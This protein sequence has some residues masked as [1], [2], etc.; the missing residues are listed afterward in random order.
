[1]RHKL[2]VPL[3]FLA[4]ALAI[5]GVFTLAPLIQVV[6]LSFQSWDG[7]APMRPW[8]GFDNYAEVLSDDAFWSALGH[9]LFWLLT[10]AIPIVIGLGLAVLLHEATP[11]GRGIYRLIYFLPYTIPVVVVAVVF[12]WIYNPVWGPLDAIVQGLTGLSVGWLGDAT[13]ALP[14]IAIAGAWVGY[15]FCMVLFLAGLAHI[16]PDLYDAA[17]TDGASALQR[18]RH[19][20]WPGLA[21]VT[22]VVVLVVFMATIRV[23]DIVYIMT[24]GGPAEATEVLGTLI[25]RE[26]FQYANVGPGSA[27]AV[28]TL[29]VILVPSI[30]YLRLR[31][32]ESA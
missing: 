30:V 12:K 10:A 15:G 4:P 9:N 20:T 18:F 27:F 19:V 24:R 8:V 11:R 16:D 14:A 2:L 32:R 28:L 23:F 5:Y 3:A 22:T 6:I 31:E 7:L 13:L 21:N 29:A 25:Y 17:K 26:T 1:M